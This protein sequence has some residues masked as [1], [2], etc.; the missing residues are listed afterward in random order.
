MKLKPLSA[1]KVI[2]VLDKLGFKIIRK[3]GSHVILKH[4]DG[5]VI[6]VPVHKGEKI[7][8]GLLRKIIKDAKISKDEFM[9]MAKEI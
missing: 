8:R 4:P 3:K 7:G 9:K 2:K 6:I 1:N 5:R